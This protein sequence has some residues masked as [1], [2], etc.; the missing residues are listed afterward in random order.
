[1]VKV[2][3]SMRRAERI[4]LIAS[5]LVLSVGGASASLWRHRAPKKPE[6]AA[7]ATPA[8]A[9]MTLNAIEVGSSAGPQIVLGTGGA[10]EFRSLSPTYHQFVFGLTGTSK[11]PMLTIP[12][13]LPA[14]GIPFA[15]DEVT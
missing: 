5:M 3:R 4:L 6:Q 13:P 1:M 11:S 12:S 2:G 10:P 7:P 8:A 14:R 9:A 15:A